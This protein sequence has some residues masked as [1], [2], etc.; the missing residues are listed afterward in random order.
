[1]VCARHASRMALRGPGVNKSRKGRG[2]C[3]I[4][5]PDGDG[6]LATALPGAMRGAESA[7]APMSAASGCGRLAGELYC[8]TQGPAGAGPTGRGTRAT[9]EL[10]AAARIWI[11][12]I[13]TGGR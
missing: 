4:L 10:A 11:A 13:V 1:M 9:P 3:G 5:P 2:Q 6:E 12:A 8:L 7:E